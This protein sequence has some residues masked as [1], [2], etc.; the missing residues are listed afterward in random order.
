LLPLIGSRP[1]KAGEKFRVEAGKS[2]LF[3]LRQ[4][5]TFAGLGTMTLVPGATKNADRKQ[6]LSANPDKATHF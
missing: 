4:A 2:V 3:S 6:R 5:T 1:L